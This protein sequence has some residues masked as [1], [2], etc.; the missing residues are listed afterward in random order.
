M[1]LT[2][3]EKKE[4]KIALGVPV[5]EK[6]PYR[7]LAKSRSRGN[8][9]ND[10]Q[11]RDYAEKHP[12]EVPWAF[13]AD[14]SVKHWYEVKKRLEE[15][16]GYV[17]HRRKNH[18]PCRDC[19][20]LKTAGMGTSH[21]GSGF[22]MYHDKDVSPSEA[23]A[24]SN[25]HQLA[26]LKNNPFSYDHAS[27]YLEEVRR[28]AEEA[29]RGIDL[30]DD[31]NVLRGY[32]Q[33]ILAKS[34]PESDPRIIKHMKRIADSLDVIRERN[35]LDSLDQ[36]VKDLRGQIDK[37]DKR[38]QNGITESGPKGLRP[39]SDITKMKTV[40]N[41]MRD[42]AKLM[43]DQWKFDAKDYITKDAFRVFWNQVVTILRSEEPDSKWTARVLYR[44]K[45]IGEPQTA[46][47]E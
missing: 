4:R 47:Y 8:Q 14:G 5:D 17:N 16:P 20:C 44:L 46:D 25:A 36:V 42:A 34:D 41:M 40:S 37:I 26:I 45:Q 29:E 22:C 18:K 30:K 19:W 43:G 35:D 23:L 24:V 13:N 3:K 38:W 2:P 28:K 11:L 7:C 21:Y 27:V 9:A 32:I 10:D 1:K 15:I 39:A 12:E 33:E 6:V 31:I